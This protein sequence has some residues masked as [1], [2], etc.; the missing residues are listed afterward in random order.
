LPLWGLL[1]MVLITSM[2]CCFCPIS[3]S[4]WSNHCLRPTPEVLTGEV[5]EDLNRCVR[6]FWLGMSTVDCMSHMYGTVIRVLYTVPVDIWSCDYR[7]WHMAG[8]QPYFAVLWWLFMAVIRVSICMQQYCG[9]YYINLYKHV[10]AVGNVYFNHCNHK[11]CQWQSLGRPHDSV[12][13]D[14][15][16]RVSIQASNFRTWHWP[17][18]FVEYLQCASLN[19]TADIDVA[20]WIYLVVE[21]LSFNR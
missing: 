13:P 16:W 5:F 1:L 8:F 15:S 19:Y 7:S 20:I 12:T 18:T 6:H 10:V 3:L 21:C 17:G 14:V 9:N 11:F 4:D 2:I